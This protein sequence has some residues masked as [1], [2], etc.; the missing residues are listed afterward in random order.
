MEDP[1]GIDLLIEP[2]V[3]S[4]G[5]GQ[6]RRVLPWRAR[7][8]VGPFTYADVMGPE[9]FAPGS[10]LDVDAHPHIGL[11][12]V[13]YLVEGRIRHRDS[14]GVVQV[15]EA[16]AVN[17]M[18]AGEGVTHTERT[19]D[20]DRAAGASLFGVQTWVALPD[21]RE[22]GPPGFEHLDADRVP[23]VEADGV[24]VR[25]AVG[26]GWGEA[27]PVA[28]ASP[29]V[30][31]DVALSGGSVPVDTGHPEV[32][33]LALDGDVRVDGFAVGPGRL[34]VLDGPRRRTLSGTGRAVV[35]GGEPV[36]PRHIWWNFVHSDP[37][38]IEAAKDRWRRQAFPT[39]PGDHDP[40]VPLP[41]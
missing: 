22:D 1:A 40:Y 34:A 37:E 19:L 7:R 32:G 39:V 9:D 24:Q 5:R 33:V 13:T 12:T 3:R 8:T 38:R 16:G 36:G 15:V 29:L 35:L 14:T 25:V 10:G 6:V 23:V 30:L 41:S 21:D 2:R 28:G 27:S 11:A 31:A 17:W 26:T 4:I 20:E 18:T